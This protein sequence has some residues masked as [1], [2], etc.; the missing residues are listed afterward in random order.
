MNAI[1]TNLKIDFARSGRSGVSHLSEK[2]EFDKGDPPPVGNKAVLSARNEAM[3]VS[4]AKINSAIVKITRDL[5]KNT[6]SMEFLPGYSDFLVRYDGFGSI[7]A[8]IVDGNG[9][10]R[11][12]KRWVEFIEKTVIEGDSTRNVKS[13]VEFK[14]YKVEYVLNKADFTENEAHTEMVL[15]GGLNPITILVRSYAKTEKE[16]KDAERHGRIP[17]PGLMEIVRIARDVN[18]QNI[19]K[20]IRLKQKIEL[21]REGVVDRVFPTA[22]DGAD[23]LPRPDSKTDRTDYMDVERSTRIRYKLEFEY[24][25]NGQPAG[26]A[27]TEFETENLTNEPPQYSYQLNSFRRPYPCE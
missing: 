21:C 1:S 16:R 7:D 12:K 18:I 27:K 11:V 6:F 9:G 24:V 23:F 17:V 15:N 2:E 19:T 22:P 25:I 14:I 13:P 4:S 5:T 8:E 20:D 26:Y 10:L 3:T